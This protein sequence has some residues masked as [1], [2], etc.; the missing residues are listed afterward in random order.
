MFMVPS[1]QLF[2]QKDN[3]KIVAQM[4]KYYK[5]WEMGNGGRFV[6]TINLPDF[7]AAHWYGQLDSNGYLTGYG[8]LQ[9]FKNPKKREYFSGK[10]CSIIGYFEKGKIHGNA[11]VSFKPQEQITDIKYDYRWTRDGTWKNGKYINE[12]LAQAMIK[13]NIEQYDFASEFELASIND[14]KYEL[15]QANFNNPPFLE[16]TSLGYSLRALV[17][18]KAKEKEYKI[19]FSVLKKGIM[20]EKT[21]DIRGLNEITRKFLARRGAAFLYT[22][23]MQMSVNEIAKGIGEALGY[24][25]DEKTYAIASK[26][27][28]VV[29]NKCVQD[30]NKDQKILEK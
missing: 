28:P 19:L 7:S 21:Y 26:W 14:I 15:L 1:L 17:S 4:V 20:S 5:D 2:A 3:V 23:M 30:K 10:I 25:I 16:N 12:D 8:K 13:E 11:S 27:F 18:W 29:Y 9:I 6:N 22:E 24:K